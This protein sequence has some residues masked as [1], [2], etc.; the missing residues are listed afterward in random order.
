M[1]VLIILILILGLLGT[2]SQ[3]VVELLQKT[4]KEIMMMAAGLVSL[5]NSQLFRVRTAMEKSLLLELIS[6]PVELVSEFWLE[7]CSSMLWITGPMSAGRWAQS[8]MVHLQ[9]ICSL[10]VMKVLRLK[11]IGRMQNW[12]LYPV[13][14]RQQKT[15]LSV[16]VLKRTKLFSLL[17]LLAVLDQLQFSSLRDEVQE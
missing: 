1:Q 6:I 4:L 12:H 16:Q 3:L 15:Y 7:R 8:A 13:H 14:T 9:N 10:L 11:V 5:W 17:E 2:Q